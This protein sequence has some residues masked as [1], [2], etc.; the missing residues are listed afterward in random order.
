VARGSV[1]KSQSVELEKSEGRRPRRAGARTVGAIVVLGVVVAFI[2]ENSQNV[3][4]HLFGLT[5]HVRLLWLVVICIAI[6]AAVEL[7]LRR[8][9]RIRFRGRRQKEL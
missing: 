1:D 8:V 7:L 6:G 2:V 4:L 3:P 5:G 9:L